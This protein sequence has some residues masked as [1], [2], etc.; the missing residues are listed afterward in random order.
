MVRAKGERQ[1]ANGEMLRASLGPL[2]FI[3]DLNLEGTVKP[4]KNAESA[5]E[6]TSWHQLR[7]LNTEQR[8]WNSTSSGLKATFSPERR[9][10]R[11]CGFCAFL[12]PTSVSICVNPWLKSFDQ[13]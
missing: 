6:R 7:T 12:W 4:R 2:R 10:Q 5:K 13:A 9:R 3:S 8:T 1:R 11:F